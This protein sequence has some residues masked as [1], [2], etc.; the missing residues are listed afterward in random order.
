MKRRHRE[1]SQ[2][3]KSL[4]GS[5]GHYSSLGCCDKSR[6]PIEVPIEVLGCQRH[7]QNEVL[8]DILRIC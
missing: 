1:V 7:W 6:V 2:L 8:M 5:Q 3:P 4:T